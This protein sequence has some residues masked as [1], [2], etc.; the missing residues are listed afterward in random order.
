MDVDAV[1]EINACEN[2]WN[3]KGFA[4]NTSRS[5]NFKNTMFK[6]MRENLAWVELYVREPYCELIHQKRH[7][8]WYANYNKQTNSLLFILSFTD[9]RI[10][11][12]SN[13]GGILGFCIG[14]SFISLVEIT[15]FLLSSAWNKCYQN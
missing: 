10:N 4:G 2:R 11:F 8:T 1:M 7:S 3:K 15:W 13:L 14:A 6:Y 5:E 9:F 12:L